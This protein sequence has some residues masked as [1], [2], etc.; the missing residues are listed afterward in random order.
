[1]TDLEIT[2]PDEPV[3]AV[4][5]QGALEVV[6]L[7]E[8]AEAT[9]VGYAAV[10]AGIAVEELDTVSG[11]LQG[12][13]Y[14]RLGPLCVSAVKTLHKGGRNVAT[15]KRQSD[16]KAFAVTAAEARPLLFTLAPG[17]PE[18]AGRQAA[19]MYSDILGARSNSEPA[20]E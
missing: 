2:V 15:L 16:G 4:Y 6:Y 13:F 17:L 11:E 3:E 12:L 8:P 5:K 18:H 9:R 7:V 10:S 20:S 1:M 19:R 14:R